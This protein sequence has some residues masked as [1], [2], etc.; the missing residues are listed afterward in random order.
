M[1]AYCESKQKQL[2]KNN[3]S[4]IMKSTITILVLSIVFTI[5]TFASATKSYQGYVVLN[6]DEKVEGTIQ[7]LS[8]T[9]NELK[10]KFTSADGEKA[11]YKAKEVKEYSFKVEKWNSK[12]R[13]HDVK[14]IT[15]VRQNVERS[16]I[17]FGPTNVLV[18]R[19]ETGVV[20]MYNHFVETNNNVKNP[21]TQVIYVQKENNDLVAIT[22][23]NYRSVLKDMVAEYPE[24]SAKVGIKGYGFKYV[25]Q[26]VSTYN[27]WM[28]DNGEEMALGMR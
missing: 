7:M 19:Q 11:T 6:N 12:T 21:Y 28:T 8:P 3:N 13:V 16:P 18:E 20:N 4:I 9:L 27:A 10:V 2:F 1:A 14:T 25:A 22:K 26:I 15:Y 24:L 5:S 23:S 17:A